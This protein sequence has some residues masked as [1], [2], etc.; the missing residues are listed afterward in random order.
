MYY[1]TNRYITEEVVERKLR[2]LATQGGLDTDVEAWKL[3]LPLQGIIDEQQIDSTSS[4]VRNGHL[5]L[6]HQGYA[7][8]P[9]P[10]GY[11]R[12]EI[13]GAPPTR[14]GRPRTR[15]VKHDPVAEMVRKQ[16][17]NA[18]NGM[19]LAEGCRQYNAAVRAL[20]PEE[21]A[22]YFDPRGYKNRMG[23]TSYRRILS[24]PLY[25]GIRSYGK[26]VS[27]WDT[28]ADYMK[29]PKR[30]DGP[31]LQQACEDLRIVSDELFDRVQA[32]F[33]AEWRGK[34]GPR[35]RSGGKRRLYHFVPD[36]FHCAHCGHRV[37]YTH[38]RNTRYFCPNPD[39]GV[40][41]SI[42]AEKAVGAVVEKLKSM[43]LDNP[44]L[45]EDIVRRTQ[46]WA[47]QDGAGGL[48][49]RIEEAERRARTAANRIKA[50]LDGIGEEEQP[51]RRRRCCVNTDRNKP[52]PRPTY[53]D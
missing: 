24:N 17:E 20:P 51:R 5:G 46:H 41:M 42:N 29:Q 19:P 27:Q 9:T 45:V 39:C 36:T 4:A 10:V 47:E 18:A 38:T 16:Y 40:P 44:E 22:A 48:G 37:Y 26:T 25:K 13:P 7:I 2:A 30:K 23:L 33:A 6:F 31:L 52:P 11:K 50:L 32:R 12:E 21:R 49:A 8:G 35:C 3:I 28:K 53:P 15:L 1:D 43:I 34:H 14:T